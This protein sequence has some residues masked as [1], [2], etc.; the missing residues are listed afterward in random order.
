MPRP[1][2]SPSDEGIRATIWIQPRHRKLWKELEN[3]GGFVNTALDDAVGVMTMAI[4]RKENPDKYTIK[5]KKAEDLLPEFNEKFP[6]DPLTAKRM[7]KKTWQEN[8]QPPPE[9]W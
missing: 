4:L 6:L 9:L 3:K 8:S 5:K 2:P 7:G 1:K